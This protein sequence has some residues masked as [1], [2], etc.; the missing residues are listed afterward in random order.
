MSCTEFDMRLVRAKNYIDLIW[1]V[2]CQPNS[3]ERVLCR[4]FRI[5]ND[6]IFE[7]YRS[8]ILWLYKSANQLNRTVWKKKWSA[9]SF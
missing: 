9:D 3:T 7:N 5:E 2:K 4:T 8:G 6:Y 1:L